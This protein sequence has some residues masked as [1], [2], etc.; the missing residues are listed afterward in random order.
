MTLKCD[1]LALTYLL[2]NAANVKQSY[3]REER[4]LMLYFRAVLFSLFTL[5]V[6]KLGEKPTILK[7]T[8]ILQHF[9]DVVGQRVNQVRFG[10]LS[11]SD[12]LLTL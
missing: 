11:A 5:H 12:Y 6:L 7:L 3:T 4:L 9:A 2:K 8:R 1:Y 10:E